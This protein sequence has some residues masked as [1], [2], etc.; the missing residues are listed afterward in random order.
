MRKTRRPATV[1]GERFISRA[2]ETVFVRTGVRLDDETLQG[3]I[4]R[5]R[6]YKLTSERD[7]LRYLCVAVASGSRLEV[8]D[9][10]WIRAV[11]RGRY[12]S[13]RG[14]MRR[15]YDVACAKIPNYHH[16]ELEA[17]TADRDPGGES[18]PVHRG[19]LDP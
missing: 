10:D 7:Y 13:E 4:A 5:A 14:R 1:G 2:S 18:G 9:A 12:R 8:P 6:G 15:L 19:P 17:A 16:G 3:L 11:L